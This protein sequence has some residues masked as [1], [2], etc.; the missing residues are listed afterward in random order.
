VTYTIDPVDQREVLASIRNTKGNSDFVIATIHA[1]DPGNFSDIPAD[2][3]PTIAHAAIDNGA[4]VF[5][6]H[7]PHRLRGI[8]IYKGKPIFYSLGNYFFELDLLEPVGMDLYEQYK[9]DPSQMTDAE[10]S[11]F[12]ADR[13]FPSEIYYQSMIAVSRYERG[14]VAEIRL[15]PIDLGYALRGADRGVPRLAAPALAKVIL[16]RMQKLSESFG[17][18]IAIE[19]NM[20]VIRLKPI[21]AT[22]NP[23]QL[24]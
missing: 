24:R 4:D 13:T 22:G 11:E 16:E 23:S 12:W 10:L 15:Y 8:E 18:S 5:V 17:T 2:Y 1:H 21:R 14:Q 9:A 20:G 3:L 19:Q 6:G 7:G